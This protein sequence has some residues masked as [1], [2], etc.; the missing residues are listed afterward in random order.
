MARKTNKESPEG[1]GRFSAGSDDDRAAEVIARIERE[2]ES[3]DLAMAGKEWPG[4]A[5][6]E[7]ALAHYRANKKSDV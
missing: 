3:L 4:M 2:E 1:S 6:F 5:A 7:R